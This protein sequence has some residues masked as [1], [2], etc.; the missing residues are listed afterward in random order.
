M[1]S[2]FVAIHTERGQPSPH[3]HLKQM[4][5]EPP[6]EDRCTVVDVLVPLLV[7]PLLVRVWVP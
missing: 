2:A 4:A 3:T 1:E 6:I 5:E 7:I